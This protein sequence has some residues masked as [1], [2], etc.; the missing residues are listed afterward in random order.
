MRD[1]KVLEE[2][3]AVCGEIFEQAER[4]LKDEKRNIQ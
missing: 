3:K 4:V 1:S 2:M